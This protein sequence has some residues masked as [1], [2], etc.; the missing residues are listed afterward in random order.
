[1]RSMEGPDH[2]A[3]L[4]PSELKAMVS[5]IRNIE[6]AMGDGIKK[7]SPSELENKSVVRKSIVALI[8]ICAGE[9]F[10]EKNLTNKRPGNGISPM[11][12]DTVL[13]RRASRDFQQDE[14]IEI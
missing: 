12:W 10:S 1:D 9:V 11:L 2:Q 13:G 4:E 6:R 5:A 3:S 8:D 7:P 14:L